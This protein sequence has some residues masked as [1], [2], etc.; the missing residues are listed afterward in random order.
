MEAC[1]AEVAASGTAR[2]PAAVCAAVWARKTPA[3][4]AAAVRT[5]EGATMATKKKSAK[6]AKKK[7]DRCSACKHG[8]KMHTRA[9]C[10][11][12]KGS[13]FCNCP[14]FAG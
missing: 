4:K 12:M 2:E 9:G 6:K 11:S 8:R 3:Q 5:Y 1:V 10:A 7:G 14:R 13:S